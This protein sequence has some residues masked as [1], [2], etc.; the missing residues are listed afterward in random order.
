M[1]GPRTM[2]SDRTVYRPASAGSAPRM[3]APDRAT[4]IGSSDPYQGYSM[5]FEPESASG[6]GSA[7]GSEGSI[8]AY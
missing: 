5:E 7:S 6:S 8:V 4:P 2:A 1:A 3:P